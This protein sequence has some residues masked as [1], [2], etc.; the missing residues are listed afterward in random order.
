ML[1]S[2]NGSKDYFNMKKPFLLFL[3]SMIAICSFGQDEE[4][5]APVTIH[6]SSADHLLKIVKN[7]F[8]SDPYSNGFGFFVKHLMDDPL[9][10]NKT[11]RLKTD[12]NLFY[13]QGAYKNYSPFSFLADRTEIRLAEKEFLENDSL[14]TKDTLFVYQLLGFNYKGKEG[15]ESVK[16]E[17]SKFNRHYGKHFSTETSDIKHGSEITGGRQDYYV[18]GIDDSPLSIAWSKIDDL[19]SVFVITL[20][21]KMH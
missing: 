10:I 17:F 11:T 9:L 4:E 3:F 7:Y 8:R 15:M 20:F 5:Q 12:T 18:Y 13:F 21:L 6:Y 1:S 14:G 19:Q 2:L 16:N